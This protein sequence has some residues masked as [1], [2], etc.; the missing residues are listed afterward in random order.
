MSRDDGPIADELRAWRCFAAAVRPFLDGLE[1]R[2]R[3][4]AG[5]PGSYVEILARLAEAPDRALRMS[6]LAGTSAFSPSRLSHAVARLEEAG[7]VRRRRLDGDRRGTV[8]E[9]TDGGAERLRAATPGYA[10]AVREHLL[11]PLDG[12]QRRALLGLGETL[13]RAAR[14]RR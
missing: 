5:L 4:E 3:R 9:L 10:A 13:G 7:L 11:G 1:R 6:R 12:E 14:G 8:V 2:V